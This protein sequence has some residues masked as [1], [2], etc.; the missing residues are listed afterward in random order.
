MITFGKGQL[1]F[2]YR[3]VGVALNNNQVLLHKSENDY[4]WSLPGGRVEFLEIARDALKREML[5]ELNIEVRVERLLWVVEN[6]FEYDK[7]FYHEL[8]LYFLMFLPDGSN[9]YSQAEQFEGNEE[10]LNLIFQWYK[11]DA[12]KYIELYP[13]FLYKSLMSIPEV[14]VHIV[15]N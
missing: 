6:F 4:F 9:L 15:Q 13:R 10:G 11:L 5:E 12:L 3:T 2:N 7:K 1:Q 14:T 8:A